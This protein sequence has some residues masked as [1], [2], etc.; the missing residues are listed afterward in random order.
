MP[1]LLKTALQT[2]ACNGLTR[3]FHF[4]MLGHWFIRG[5]AKTELL[6]R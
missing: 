5:R 4:F 6:L 2:E 1:F 3:A